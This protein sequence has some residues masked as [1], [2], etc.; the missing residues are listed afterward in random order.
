M[1]VYRELKLHARACVNFG[2]FG[3]E[4]TGA[5]GHKVAP[6]VIVGVLILRWTVDRKWKSGGGGSGMR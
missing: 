1:C 5:T 3:W 2:D 6:P 4:C